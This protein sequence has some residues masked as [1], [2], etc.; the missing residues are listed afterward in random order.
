MK[1]YEVKV[2]QQG[3]LLTRTAPG[4][5]S[6]RDWTVRRECCF[7]ETVL[8]PI[9]AYNMLS[10]A[11]RGRARE[12]DLPDDHV[13]VTLAQRGYALFGGEH[14]SDHTAKYILAVHYD[15]CFVPPSGDY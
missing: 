2:G 8:D 6:I 1:W 10:R 13:F 14:G 12:E 5:Y 9:S 11:E 4:R 3:K 15:N 7:S